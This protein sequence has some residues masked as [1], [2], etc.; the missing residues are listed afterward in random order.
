MC[1]FVAILLSMKIGHF[2]IAA[3]KLDVAAKNYKLIVFIFILG[4][5]FQHF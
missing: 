5:L 1:E 3:Q 2:S 4:M